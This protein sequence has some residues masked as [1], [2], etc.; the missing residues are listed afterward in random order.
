MT[1]M[2]MEMPEHEVISQKEKERL[3]REHLPLVKFFARKYRGM[4]CQFL[5]S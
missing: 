2:L 1:M 3:V 4:G 5:D